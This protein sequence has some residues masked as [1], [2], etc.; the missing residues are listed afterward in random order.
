MFTFVFAESGY[1]RT[2]R[3]TDGRLDIPS[4]RDAIDASKNARNGKN[5]KHVTSNKVVLGARRP[6]QRHGDHAK[7]MET[8][9][10]AWE[11]CQGH[12]D[13]AEGMGTIP[14]AKRLC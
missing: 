4:Y 1:G 2:D 12:R 14:R 5:A 7:G 11:P 6:C 3:R 10:K 9:P 8:M 13:H